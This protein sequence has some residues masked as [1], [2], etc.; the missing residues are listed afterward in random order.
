[1]KNVKPSVL[2]NI[3]P[4][5]SVF[6]NPEAEDVACYVMSALA[7]SGDT[8]RKLT[9]EEYIQIR[10][11]MGNPPGGKSKEWFSKVAPYCVSIDTIVSFSPKWKEIV[12]G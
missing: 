6:Q 11:E 1:M 3:F 12:E 4:W 9:E 2:K 7:H 5:D 8:F 10:T